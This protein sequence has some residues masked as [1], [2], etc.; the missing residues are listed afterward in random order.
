MSSCGGGNQISGNFTNASDLSVSLDRIGLDNSSTPI[1]KADMKEGKFTFPL[2]EAP[3]PGLYRITMGQ[4]N[5][6]FV[7]D[8]TESKV[9][10][11]GNFNELGSGKVEVKGSP[12]SEEVFAAIKNLSASQASFETIRSKIEETKS[13]LAAGLLAVQFLGFRADFLNYHKEVFAKLKSQYPD[14]EF[15]KTYESFISQSEEMVK[16]QEAAESIKVGMEAPEIDLPSPN[17]KNYKLS[18]LKGKVVLLD[19]WA[20]W[21][22]PCR[23]A[24]PHVVEI[25]NK[26]RSKGFTVFSVSL[27]GVDSRTKSQLGSDAQIKEFSDRAKDAWVAAIE[28][29]KLSW[30]THVSDLKKWESAPAR[31]YGVQAIPKTFL[32]GKDGKIAAVNPRDNLEE[33]VIKAL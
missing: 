27:D 18:D 9:E 17:G 12:A 29:D 14:T 5:L 4:Q 3:K 32:I 23:R 6:I 16:A 20:S 26:Y 19:F 7:L 30:E 13:P 25:Y 24:N 28:K 21:C 11:S 22:G 15:T 1:D 10:F 33:E 8:G 31:L 2:K